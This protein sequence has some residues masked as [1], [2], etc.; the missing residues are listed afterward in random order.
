MKKALIVTTVS[1]FVPQFEM[2]NVHILQNMGFEVHYAAN[3][4]MPSYGDDNSR[5]DG[6]GIIRHQVD[7][8]RSPYSRKNVKA[9]KQLLDLMKSVK[10]EL[11]HCHT[12]MGGVLARLAAHK[13]GTGP[14]IYTVH[15][16]HFYK[17]APLINWLV[18]YPVER[19]MARYTDMLITINEEDYRRA[20]RFKA[21]SVRRIHG[22]G[23]D[24]EVKTVLDEN[25]KRQL[26]ESLKLQDDKV[27]L[28]SAGELNDNK[29]HI[30]VL[31]ALAKM[32]E[33]DCYYL[34]CGKGPLK[35]KLERYAADNGLRE[36]VR[37]LGYRKDLS[38]ILQ[39]ADIFVMPSKREG[40]STAV[41][42]AMVHGLPVVATDIRGNN[43][44][45][46]DNVNGY[47]IGLDDNVS[48]CKQL[49]VLMKNEKIRKKMGNKGKSKVTNYDNS[50][51][52]KV[53]KNN[54]A[55]IL[56][57]RN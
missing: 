34:I 51:V 15:G 38:H 57:G 37:F 30:M 19:W 26:R 29:N 23:I 22:V 43:E 49:L 31:K 12:P 24:T 28:V 39:I 20:K 35:E 33:I 56:K 50:V 6:T 17:G 53:M 44:L 32:P 41:M 3:Y 5:L 25:E 8:A 9:Y 40:L 14:V 27:V 48:F 13:T 55:A 36:K 18:Y 4:D 10:F 21:K 47:L 45:V 46:V 54:Y 11:V 7:F 2:Q 52:K 1:G 16:F 42:E